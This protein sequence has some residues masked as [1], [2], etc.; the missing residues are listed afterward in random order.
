MYRPL[1]QSATEDRISSSLCVSGPFLCGLILWISCSLLILVGCGFQ[2]TLETATQS[3]NQ[4]SATWAA[5][6]ALLPSTAIPLTGMTVREIAH[7]SIGGDHAR[8]TLSNEFGID[9]LEI[10]SAYVASRTY[11]ASIATNSNVPVTF[12][13][14]TSTM[15]PPGQVL[16]SDSIPIVVTSNTDVA[17]SLGI[18][19]SK[20][21]PTGHYF[22]T[23][24][25]YIAS[26]NVSA[27]VDLVPTATIQNSY[28]LSRLEVTSTT[29]ASTIV[30]FGDSI[31]DG[32]G[33]TIDANMRWPDLLAA[34][35]AESPKYSGRSVVN[36]GL[37]GN[38]LLHDA[39]PGLSLYGLSGL[40]RFNRDAL[41]QANVKTII[42][43][44]GI[45]DLGAP[46]FQAPLSEAVSVDEIITAYQQLI[47]EAH[48]K[49]LRI[50]GATLTPIQGS[51]IFSESVEKSR[52]MVNSW[53]RTQSNFDAVIDFDF[54]TRDASLPA[55]LNPLYDS[56]DHIHLS[57]AGYLQMPNSI[58]FGIL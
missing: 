36:A 11:G 15:I 26:G 20:S 3:V 46:G 17:V 42:V 34:R 55:R 53:L 21:I 50:I 49:H 23:E 9:A 51:V 52:Q 56:G 4:W 16:I 40:H 19:N 13:G 1:A 45:N 8:I 6:Q 38:R 22:A 44:E 58:D 29:A 35:L 2:A 14:A 41:S 31:T 33:S 57:D 39:T 24:V 27:N 32:V 10:K 48:S 12:R 28:F 43:L 7:S 37:G 5:S 47:T 30:A 18:G 54:A 25:A